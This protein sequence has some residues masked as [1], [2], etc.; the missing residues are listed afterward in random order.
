MIVCLWSLLCP[1]NAQDSLALLHCLLE[2]QKRSPIKFELAAATVNPGIEVCH[3][4]C[5]AI[6]HMQQLIDRCAFYRDESGVTVSILLTIV[7]AITT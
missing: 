2:L 1:G 7:Y 5:F 4:K 3:T 6:M